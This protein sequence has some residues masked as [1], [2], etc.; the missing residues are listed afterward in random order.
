[1]SKETYEH[2]KRDLRVLTTCLQRK[3]EADALELARFHRAQ[4]TAAISALAHRFPNPKP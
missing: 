3:P 4:H 1:M 2:V